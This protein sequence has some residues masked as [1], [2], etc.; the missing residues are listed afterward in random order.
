MNTINNL[1]LKY[2]YDNQKGNK[3]SNNLI[4]KGSQKIFQLKYGKLP[5]LE[6]KNYHKALLYKCIPKKSQSMRD[7][8]KINNSKNIYKALGPFTNLF[9]SG[10]GF[11]KRIENN[12]YKNYTCLYLNNDK[13]DK[14][15]KNNRN[16]I[17]SR[18]K[19]LLDFPE[20]TNKTNY[21][22][23]ERMKNKS[24]H[25]S[26]NNNNN[27]KKI[28][29][30][31]E[32][33]K[34]RKINK[35]NINE[36]FKNIK[37]L[38]LNNENTFKDNLLKEKENDKEQNDYKIE[39][40]DKN[41]N[42]EDVNFRNKTKTIPNND[43]KN[44]Y[45][46]ILIKQSNEQFSMKNNQIK[47]FNKLIE[48]DNIL[49]NY[50]PSFN[51]RNEND[52]KTKSSFPNYIISSNQIEYAIIKDSKPKIIL[53]NS[54]IKEP[55]NINIS[56]ENNN[57][58]N[59]NITE[60]KEEENNLNENIINE[61]INEAKKNIINTSIYKTKDKVSN[62]PQLNI[63]L[64][65]NRND[66]NLDNINKN[67][68]SNIN[69]NKKT[70]NYYINK[71]DISNF[72][73]NNI[74]NNINNKNN[75][76]T[77]LNDDKQNLIKNINTKTNSPNISKK[78]NNSNNNDNL[79]INNINN[80]IDNKIKNENNETNEEEYKTKNSKQFMKFKSRISKKI[81][82]E[83][84]KGGNNINVSEKIT[85]MALELENKLKNGKPVNY[86]EENYKQEN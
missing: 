32:N 82:S 16:V 57:N 5:K 51:L 68:N 86:I 43:N 21:L 39:L 26:K 30:S 78:N 25:K 14:N 50:Y 37:D 9:N 72:K 58:N 45:N 27:E 22:I 6:K 19:S 71:S 35:I 33:S 67:S 15:M 46:N 55:S 10:G 18:N 61:N 83:F 24:K 53:E 4:K 29:S 12:K 28:N 20:K 59:I 65:S 8:S 76:K 38:K 13:K 66:S 79:K 84:K 40:S 81:G 60:K 7:F 31:R 48:V 77:N 54:N 44:Y 52:M 17:Y 80:E 70:N 63:T 11:C 42:N 75:I 62:L 74:N 85:N 1:N 73:F 36:V 47:K 49:L 34:K 64:F 41:N 56:Q 23:S 69:N 3:N 2:K